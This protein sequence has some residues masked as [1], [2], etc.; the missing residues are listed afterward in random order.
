MSN[1]AC[2]LPPCVKGPAGGALISCGNSCRTERR[3]MRRPSLE[4]Y[5]IGKVFHHMKLNATS[6]LRADGAP[7][8]LNAPW[9][10][11]VSFDLKRNARLKRFVLKLPMR[12]GISCVGGVTTRV[13]RAPIATLLNVRSG[14]F[15]C[16]RAGSK[17]GRVSGGEPIF[18]SQGRQCGAGQT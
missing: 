2:R 8:L 12:V 13:R 10:T 7:N 1:F 6:A 5:A 4:S 18:S 16:I 14:S 3:R 11:M 15:V 17:L 9:V